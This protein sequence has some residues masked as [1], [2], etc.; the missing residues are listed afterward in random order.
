MS[1]NSAGS[2]LPLWFVFRFSP[3]S[4]FA[5]MS[6]WWI[7]SRPV[8]HPC[9]SSCSISHI[10]LDKTGECQLMLTNSSNI[11]TCELWGSETVKYG[12]QAGT[13]KQ[14]GECLKLFLQIQLFV[15][16]IMLKCYL[17]RAGK[18]RQIFCLYLLI[19][20]KKVDPIRCLQIQ[21]C[22]SHCIRSRSVLSST[23][24]VTFEMLD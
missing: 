8:H 3:R 4:L 9:R 17:N 18:S 6:M 10:I 20:V 1:K 15:H 24:I 21:A 11:K 19:S 5:I 2:V 7:F 16:F 22:I 12:Q 14:T 23:D 13:A